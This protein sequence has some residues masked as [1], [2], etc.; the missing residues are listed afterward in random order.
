[1]SDLHCPISCPVHLSQSYTITNSIDT[2]NENVPHT[3]HTGMPLNWFNDIAINFKNCIQGNEIDKLEELLNEI[4][5]HA[6]PN[7]LE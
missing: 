1:M 6:N 4:T 3:R 5:P 7:D 2:V